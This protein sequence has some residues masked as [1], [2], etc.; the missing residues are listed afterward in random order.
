[1]VVGGALI[2]PAGYLAKLRGM[3]P[4]ATARE[5]E[6]VERAAV[7]AVLDAEAALNRLPREM[8]RNNRGYDIESKTAEGEL[9]FIEVKGRIAGAPT[10]TIT[11]SEI[12]VGQNKS[13]QFILALVEVPS[14]EAPEVRYLRRPFEAGR[15]PYFA[16]V[17]T[18]FDWRQLWDTA[19]RPS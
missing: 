8:P 17:S 11:R 15:E 4:A 3:Q 10:V 12:G 19:S 6:R 7:Q 18:N 2:L 13:D 5:T 16:E 1:M 9:L 14:E